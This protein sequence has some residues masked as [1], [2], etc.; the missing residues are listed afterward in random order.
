MVVNP[1]PTTAY[2]GGIPK[3]NAVLQITF[4]ELLRS[5]SRNISSP[6]CGV[7]V[8]HAAGSYMR[9]NCA[10]PILV[11]TLAA[12]ALCGCAS[13]EMA[14]RFLASPDKYMLYNCAELATEARGDA[15]RLRELE[16]LM[17]KAG[18]DASGRLV[19]NM[20]YG[21]EILQVRGRMDQQRKTAAEKNCNLSAGGGGRAQQGLRKGPLFSATRL[22]GRRRIWANYLGGYAAS[23]EQAMRYF[24]AR[25]IGPSN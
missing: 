13:D 10:L 9:S 11:I 7:R 6:C 18:V 1:T 14:G 19:G 16:A 15:N 3:G 20:A 8:S 25:Y 12:M 5:C 23:R 17:T 24:K 22:G 4:A 21:A 2:Q